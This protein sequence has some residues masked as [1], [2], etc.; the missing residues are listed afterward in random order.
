MRRAHGVRRHPYPPICR[1]AFVL[2]GTRFPLM[3]QYASLVQCF[4]DC[5][6]GLRR[7]AFDAATCRA[8]PSPV[9]CPCPSHRHAMHF[10][11][12]R[13]LCPASRL[14]DRVSGRRRKEAESMECERS[15]ALESLTRS[16]KASRRR[17]GSDFGKMMVLVEVFSDRIQVDAL[18]YMSYI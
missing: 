12:V 15:L 1:R 13:D 4:R 10:R 11:H 14:F 18:G 8:S 3:L 7:P 17:S 2:R 5:I 16:Q 9:G 6:T